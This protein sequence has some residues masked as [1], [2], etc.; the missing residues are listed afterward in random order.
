MDEPLRIQYSY[1][2]P[3]TGSLCF[4][5][6]K[7]L[8]FQHAGM[9]LCCPQ[10]AAAAASF[11]PA[12]PLRELFLVPSMSPPAPLLGTLLQACFLF[13]SSGLCCPKAPAVVLDMK[14]PS[15]AYVF[16][17]LVPRTPLFW[18]V[19][20]HLGGDAQLGE[21]GPWAPCSPTL[22]PILSLL[23]LSHYTQM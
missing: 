21:V 18:E 19:V 13:L 5:P 11:L 23:L 1:L 17:L 3:S 4:S 7:Q 20:E 22:L 12:V 15:Q 9:P 2:L 10:N 6:L 16:E 8:L 14:C